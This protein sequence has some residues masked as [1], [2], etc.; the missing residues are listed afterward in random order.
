MIFDHKSRARSARSESL[1]SQIGSSVT[2][3]PEPVLSSDGK[4]A[5][6]AVLLEHLG[7]DI[8]D[9]LSELERR[10]LYDRALRP[11]RL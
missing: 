11:S 8:F 10:V 2:G 4:A 7:Q 6:D 3:T 5:Q 1:G 9:S